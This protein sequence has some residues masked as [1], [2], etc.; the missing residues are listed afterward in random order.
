MFSMHK[1]NSSIHFRKKS[2][3]NEDTSTPKFDGSPI[4]QSFPR[5]RRPYGHTKSSSYWNR[6]IIALVLFSFTI[7]STTL[8]SPAKR[9]LSTSR[10]TQV[11]LLRSTDTSGEIIR[12]SKLAPADGS[13]ATNTASNV[14]STKPLFLL[15]IGPPKTG[16]TTLQCYLGLHYP[17]LANQNNFFYLG[18]WYAPLCGLPLNYS[19]DG[20][21]DIP[22]PSLLDCYAPHIHKQCDLDHQWTE[23]GSILQAHYEQGH[24]II[25]S[26]EMFHHHFQ[27]EDV[28]RLAIILEPWNVRIMFTYRHFY[29]SVPSMY[30]QLNDPYA[31]EEGMANAV[32]KT[33]WP[34]EGGYRIESF[35]IANNFDVAE[36]M[37]R[38]SFWE[39]AF[40]DVQV[41]NMEAVAGGSHNYL[42]SFLCTMMPEAK[43]TL[44]NEETSLEQSSHD[45]RNDNGSSSKHLH[46]DMLAVAAKEQG[47]LDDSSLNRVEV[48]DAVQVYCESNDWTTLDTFPLDCLTSEEL[49]PF[50]EQSLYQAQIM[51]TYI[52]HSS[53]DQDYVTMETEIR[54]GFWS[55]AE[56]NQF[57]S[58]NAN[59][60]LHTDERWQNFFHDLTK[61]QE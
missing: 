1:S 23:F 10:I 30:H 40:G 24:N 53:P 22:R 45:A 9:A 58:V 47:L 5:L 31:T 46:Y 43:S 33:M 50:L 38:F 41:F 13:E 48:R 61:I 52:V 57:C 54:S 28:A 14:T 35:R 26:D 27:Q 34:S 15:H 44:C 7:L 32:E 11:P 19:I 2:G 6:G 55:Y 36:E 21:V 51:E 8:P 29:A 25:M 17:K 20:F 39:S 12:S 4:G 60:T 37:H 49:Q 16:T 59:L 42:P 3:D 56:R 18:T